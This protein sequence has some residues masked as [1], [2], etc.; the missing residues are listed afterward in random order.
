M[1]EKLT[2]TPDQRFE[3]DE[4][5]GEKYRWPA[6]FTEEARRLWNRYADTAGSSE[7]AFIHVIVPLV[8][9]LR[10]E[11][12]RTPSFKLPI[13]Y[14]HFSYEGDDFYD[15]DGDPITAAQLVEFINGK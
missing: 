2:S 4:Y 9:A 7:R 3:I 13:R 1:T 6:Q 5:T 12:A 8:A 10:S 11:I 15:A 14:E